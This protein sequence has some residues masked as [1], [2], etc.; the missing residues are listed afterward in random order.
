MLVNLKEIALERGKK[1][2]CFLLSSITIYRYISAACF[3]ANIY[4]KSFRC[5]NRHKSLL[6]FSYFPSA[7]SRLPPFFKMASFFEPF[8]AIIDMKCC[9]FLHLDE[10]CVFVSEL[11]A[12]VSVANSLFFK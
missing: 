3:C 7:S 11:L 6:C 8:K 1:T 12:T 9:L 5:G 2:L 4:K 10:L